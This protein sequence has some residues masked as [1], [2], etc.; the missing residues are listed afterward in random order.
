MTLERPLFSPRAENHLVATQ[1]PANPNVACQPAQFCGGTEPAKSNPAQIGRRGL[2][3]GLLALAPFAAATGAIASG[4]ALAFSAPEAAL[5]PPVQS[6][7]RLVRLGRQLDQANTAFGEAMVCL[8]RCHELALQDW[9]E[10]AKEIVIGRRSW[11]LE[12]CRT[13]IERDIDGNTVHLDGEPARQIA[14]AYD[15]EDHLRFADGRTRDARAAKRMLPLAKEYEATK[16]QAVR[17]SGYD[18]AKSETRSLARRIERIATLIYKCECRTL[19]GV[20]IKARALLASVG[21]SAVDECS[22]HYYQ[23]KYSTELAKQITRL[24]PRRGLTAS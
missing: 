23:I 18:A 15:L 19:E 20:A 14:C 4:P 6:E 21:T 1:I 7:R 2:L 24:A 9:P 13:E 22:A 10:P 17:R 3:R 8:A 12:W 5:V 16:E 11:M